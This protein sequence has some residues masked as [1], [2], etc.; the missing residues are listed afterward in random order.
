MQT[1][2]TN[3]TARGGQILELLFDIFFSYG[4][5]P[6]CTHVSCSVLEH[7]VDT[8]RYIIREDFCPYF[9]YSIDVTFE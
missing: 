7:V 6:L 3:L 5:S 2:D 1:S 9:E 8:D 4:Q